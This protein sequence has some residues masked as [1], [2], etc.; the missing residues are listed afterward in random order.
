MLYLALLQMV[1]PRKRK[2]NIMGGQVTNAM[3]TV[4]PQI[5][6]VAEVKIK[7]FDLKVMEKK[8]GNCSTA[9]H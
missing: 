7:W 5:R 8:K 1:W 9:V 6:T 2:K 4:S 3:D